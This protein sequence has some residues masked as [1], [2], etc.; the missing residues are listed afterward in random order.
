[1]VQYFYIKSLYL[2]ERCRPL[3]LLVVEVEAWAWA[4][5]H[6]TPLTPV[7]GRLSLVPDLTALA[8][9]A[10]STVRANRELMSSWCWWSE[11]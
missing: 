6:P 9:A 7:V 4:Q 10:A 5:T 2:H 8:T 3:L 1:M 11:G